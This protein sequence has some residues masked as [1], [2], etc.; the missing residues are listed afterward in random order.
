MKV[1]RQEPLVSF[2]PDDIIRTLLGS[3]ESTI[4]KEY[5]LSF[6]PVEVFSFDNN[7]LECDFAQGLFFKSRRPG[8]FQNFLIDVHQGYKHLKNISG[9]VHWYMMESK[10]FNSSI[11][12]KSKN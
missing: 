12:F 11:T 7:F 10:V 6:N 3:N 9:G 8:I 4:Y 2:T 5:N 1:S